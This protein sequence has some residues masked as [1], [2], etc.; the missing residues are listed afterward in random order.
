VT[1]EVTAALEKDCP[2]GNWTSD[3][4]LET[5]NPAVAKLRI[6]V[7]VNVAAPLAASPSAVSFGDLKMGSS[8]EKTVTIASKSP[9]KILQVKGAD[10]QV[11]V[12]IDKDVAQASHTLTILMHPKA[13]GGVSRKVE[14]ITDSKD[15][16]K[17][18]VPVTAKVVEN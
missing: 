8:A 3:I 1:Y 2:A 7:T 9:F 17:V 11:K 16:P 18:V 4:Y 15:Q 6:P 12:K 14:I 5:S 10:E 13:A